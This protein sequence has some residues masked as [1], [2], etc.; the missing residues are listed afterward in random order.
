[1]SVDWKDKD[2]V[3]KYADKLHKRHGSDLL[4][5]KYISNQGFNI[6]GK[7][8]YEIWQRSDVE[9]IHETRT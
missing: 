1:M 7:D 9:V 4:V 2:T 5:I 6:I 8:R 3:I